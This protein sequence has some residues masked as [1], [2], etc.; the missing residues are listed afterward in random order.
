MG[1]ILVL[2]IKKE[3]V[4]KKDIIHTV[5][6]LNKFSDKSEKTA[7]SKSCKLKKG[8]AYTWQKVK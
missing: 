8:A 5:F 6:C 2:K 3:I 7:F 4:F 1:E